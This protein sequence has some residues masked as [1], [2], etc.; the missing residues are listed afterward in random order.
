MSSARDGGRPS[1]PRRARRAAGERDGG[2]KVGG[3]FAPTP[4]ADPPPPLGGMTL[5]PPSGDDA[6]GPVKTVIRTPR[7]GGEIRQRTIRVNAGTGMWEDPGAAPEFFD[8]M[9]DGWDGGASEALDVVCGVAADMRNSGDADPSDP[10]HTESIHRAAWMVLGRVWSQW[11][12]SS[13]WTFLNRFKSPVQRR[14]QNPRTFFNPHPDGLMVETA[15]AARISALCRARVEMWDEDEADAKWPPFRSAG[16]LYSYLG[17]FEELAQNPMLWLGED[18]RMLERMAQH[19]DISGRSLLLAEDSARRAERQ[20]LAWPALHLLGLED[21]DE[22][23]KRDALQMLEGADDFWIIPLSIRADEAMRYRF[24]GRYE[25]SATADWMRHWERALRVYAAETGK[26]RA[27]GVLHGW[28]RSQLG[29]ASSANPDR[30]LG[31][32]AKIAES[33]AVVTAPGRV[34]I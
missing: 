34:V 20:T 12:G 11:E 13:S 3:R 33:A 8:V 14:P 7:I 25:K 19:R 30:V 6:A 15:A 18:G 23:V 28:R 32:R 26:T 17:D 27:T 9:L 22:A 1:A 2:V 24:R 5:G 29:E 16:D 10:D 21:L 31:R 4:A